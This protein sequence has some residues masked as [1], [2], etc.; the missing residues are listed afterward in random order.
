M[1]IL[2]IFDNF[3]QFL[4]N[5]DYFWQ[6]LTMSDNFDNFDN[7]WQFWSFWPFPLGPFESRIVTMPNDF[8]VFP[9]LLH[10]IFILEPYC[11]IR[12]YLTNLYFEIFWN[13]NSILCR[14]KIDIILPR[15][16]IDVYNNPTPPLFLSMYALDPCFVLS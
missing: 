1:I 10:L 3:W 15:S 6:C 16:D 4:T 12:A 13:D 14:L 8:K 11:I 7:F 2:T 5:M 9:M